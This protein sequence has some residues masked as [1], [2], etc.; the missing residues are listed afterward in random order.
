M[1]KISVFN[2]AQ[3]NANISCWDHKPKLQS[4]L[5]VLHYC[6]CGGHLLSGKAQLCNS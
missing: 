6:Y 4:S 5:N 1:P 3:S 2:T